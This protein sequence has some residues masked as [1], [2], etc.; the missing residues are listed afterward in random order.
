[1]LVLVDYL[2]RERTVSLPEQ[3]LSTMLYPLSYHPPWHIY[4]TLTAFWDVTVLPSLCGVGGETPGSLSLLPGI[5]TE[6]VRCS[7]RSWEQ[8]ALNI[9]ICIMARQQNQRVTKNKETVAT[10]N[11]HVHQSPWHSNAAYQEKDTLMHHCYCNC[12]H[13]CPACVWYTAIAHWARPVTQLPSRCLSHS[14]IKGL[15]V[16][17]LFSARLFVWYVT[18][19]PFIA[20]YCQ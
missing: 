2:L 18:N 1:M 12:N 11:P 16:P 9:I 4:I 13:I 7:K 15:K 17:V 6:V 8:H 19:N 10:V 3:M 14:H 20:S 5:A